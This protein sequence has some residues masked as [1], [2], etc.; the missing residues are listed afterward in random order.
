MLATDSLYYVAYHNDVAKLVIALNFYKL[1]MIHL[2]HDN[3]VYMVHEAHIVLMKCFLILYTF[4]VKK[5]R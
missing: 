2:Q 5:C 1:F 3:V 4:N